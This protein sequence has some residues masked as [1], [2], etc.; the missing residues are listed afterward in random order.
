METPLS[1]FRGGI[2]TVKSACR[3]QSPRLTLILEV[4]CGKTELRQLPRP[5]LLILSSVAHQSFE[6]AV[7]WTRN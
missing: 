6:T 4:G 7:F 3:K 5:R 1:G 2:N